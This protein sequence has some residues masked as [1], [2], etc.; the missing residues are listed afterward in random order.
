MLEYVTYLYMLIHVSIL[1]VSYHCMYT[2]VSKDS[3]IIL[4]MESL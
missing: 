3:Q 1:Y 4:E 2:Y